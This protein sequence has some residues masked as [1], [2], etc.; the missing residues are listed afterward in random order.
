MVKYNSSFIRDSSK[1]QY[2]V[3]E[4]NVK[5]VYVDNLSEVVCLTVE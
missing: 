2:K 4:N 1:L 5:G 3:K